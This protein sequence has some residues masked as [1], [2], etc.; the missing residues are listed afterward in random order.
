VA[1]HPFAKHNSPLMGGMAWGI[2]IGGVWGIP[3]NNPRGCPYLNRV[4]TNG[5]PGQIQDQWWLLVAN[6]VIGPG[7]VHGRV[8]GASLHGI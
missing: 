6:L 3:Q 8:F 4:G 5:Y 1:H 7:K 2:K